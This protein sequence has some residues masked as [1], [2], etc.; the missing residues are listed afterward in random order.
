MKEVFL[1]RH[2]KSDW[3]HE[4]LNDIDRPLNE[5]GYADAYRMAKLFKDKFEIPDKILSSPATRAINTA[6][7]FS[8][9]FNIE[10]EKVE[11][12]KLIF[13]ASF[14]TITTVISKI[15]NSINSIILFG[16]N[17]GLTNFINE[18]SDAVLD[19]L[20]TCGIVRIKFEI[21]NWDE[22]L[23]HNG[24]FISSEFPKDFRS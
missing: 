17:P 10:E 3:A 9:I 24:L 12:E 6:F 15:D 8:R 1:V 21:S 7:I 20:P 4:F 19:N 5:R 11:I 13:E 18:K 23:N 2:A 14:K 16:H 22:I